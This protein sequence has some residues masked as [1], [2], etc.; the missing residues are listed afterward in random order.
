MC[1]D[2]QIVSL[3]DA[4]QGDVE[5][6]LRAAGMPGLC[7][8]HIKR[9]R[10]EVRVRF[11]T[12]KGNRNNVICKLLPRSIELGP[13]ETRHLAGRATRIVLFDLEWQRQ[14]SQFWRQ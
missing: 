3:R 9:R 1:D 4:I 2:S 6:G 8:V 14:H 13:Y 5:A 7:D 11:T 12:E 10:P